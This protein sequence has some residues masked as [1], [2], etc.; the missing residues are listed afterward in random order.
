MLRLKCADIRPDGLLVSIREF[1]SRCPKALLFSWTEALREA[2]D[3]SI[4]LY[5]RKSLV[6]YLFVFRDKQS[7]YTAT[8]FKSNWNRWV[9]KVVEKG[10]V[11]AS[12]TEKDIRTTVGNNMASNREAQLLLEH[13]KVKTT[14]IHYRELLTTEIV[15]PAR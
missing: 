7:H 1:K 8:G 13:K 5:N 11:K 10:I 15:Q 6:Y 14:K 3:E 4:R 12:F 2:V 9:E